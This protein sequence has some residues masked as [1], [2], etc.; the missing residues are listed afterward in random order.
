MGDALGLGFLRPVAALGGAKGTTL[1]VGVLLGGGREQVGCGLLGGS[2][3]WRHVARLDV[4]VT[5]RAH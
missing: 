3:W 4:R 2:H 5:G 1:P